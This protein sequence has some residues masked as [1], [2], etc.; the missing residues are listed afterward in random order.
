MVSACVPFPPPIPSASPGSAAGLTA[1]TQVVGPRR[2]RRR[3]RESALSGL[4]LFR[5]ALGQQQGDIELRSGGI[6][7]LA[8]LGGSSAHDEA[9]FARP[10]YLGQQR[11][12][13]KWSLEEEEELQRGFER[14]GNQ[15]A[16]ILKA[17]R[18]HSS[19][20]SVDLKDKYR[21][22]TKKHMQ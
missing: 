18:F 6:K 20:T 7:P 17:F 4:P 9:S 14:Y 2:A 3:A 8:T 5:V 11:K 15:W 1:A 10:R 12:R 22:M 19:R 21:N 13:T 16:D